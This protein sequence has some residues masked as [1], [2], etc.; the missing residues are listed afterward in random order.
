M[1]NCY[2]DYGVNNIHFVPLKMR[3]RKIK[4]NVPKA[5]APTAFTADI[6]YCGSS[7]GESNIHVNK[8]MLRGMGL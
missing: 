6:S 7:G 8:G 5:R 3:R 4:H 1:W 2:S